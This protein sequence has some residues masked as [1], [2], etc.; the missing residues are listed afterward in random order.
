MPGLAASS[1][2]LAVVAAVQVQG[3]NVQQESAGGDG[4]QGWFE[5]DV[6]VAVRP[7]DDPADG[8]PAQ[9]G[10]DRPLPADLGLVGG[11][12]ASPFTAAGGFVQ[13]AAGGDLG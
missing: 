8:D 11:A 3:L 1:G 10:G 5:Q 13:A 12:G 6:V 2:E 4:L 9:V 7:V